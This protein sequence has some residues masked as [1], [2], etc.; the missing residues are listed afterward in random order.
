MTKLTRR[1]DWLERLLAF[2]ETRRRQPMVW[3][4]NDPLMFIADAAKEI[5]GTDPFD[6]YRGAYSNLEQL[7]AIYESRGGIE[8]FMGWHLGPELGPLSA[9][10]GDAVLLQLPE[11]KT[12]GICLGYH[13]ATPG[14]DALLII[15]TSNRGHLVWQS[16]DS[17]P[18]FPSIASWRI[19]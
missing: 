6:A 8:A 7:S 13:I 15:P 1:I 10:R 5:T 2:V 9:R 3:G 4:I 14:L 18:G 19:A 11:S 16:A 17:P 12:L